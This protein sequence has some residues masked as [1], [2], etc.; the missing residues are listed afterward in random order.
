MDLEHKY[1][2]TVFYYLKMIDG[3]YHIIKRITF[4]PRIT[5]E[6]LHVVDNIKEAEE[7]VE[8]LNEG[9]IS[10]RRYRKENVFDI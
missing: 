5:L 6:E 2:N 7:I 1:R 8:G 10:E 3:K 9:K 4:Q